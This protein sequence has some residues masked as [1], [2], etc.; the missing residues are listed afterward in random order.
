MVLVRPTPLLLGA[1][2][3]SL[4]L[5][6]APTS[7]AFSAPAPPPDGIKI[8]GLP[9]G[10]IE[11]LPG[12]YV[13]T[14]RRWIVD[15]SDDGSCD[16]AE[17]RIQATQKAEPLRGAGLAHLQDGWVDPTSTRELWWPG[18]LATVQARPALNV[19]LRNGRLSYAGAGMDVRVPRGGD[20]ATWRNYGL[21]SQP[22]ART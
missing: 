21:H 8:V 20:D 7:R 12:M 17:G 9:G 4:A 11:S 6:A 16:D 2:L 15:G 1:S 5:L 13:Q 18:D 19:L 10:K 22:I 14:F 3:P